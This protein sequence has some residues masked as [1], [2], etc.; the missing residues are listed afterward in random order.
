LKYKYIYL[1]A[2]LLPADDQ[3]EDESWSRVARVIAN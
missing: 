1:S 2:D 3:C